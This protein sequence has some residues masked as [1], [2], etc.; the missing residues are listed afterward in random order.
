MYQNCFHS[1]QLPFGTVDPSIS[2]PPSGSR[3]VSSGNDS[4]G[5][6]TIAQQV[7]IINNFWDMFEK[8]PSLP[9]VIAYVV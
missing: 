7:S 3:L 8:P 6:F 1:T 5:K 9:N 2:S 4:I